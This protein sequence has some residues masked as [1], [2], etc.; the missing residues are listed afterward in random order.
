MNKE[1]FIKLFELNVIY[2]EYKE[3]IPFSFSLY[4]KLI[5]S[6]TFIFFGFDKDHN[7]RLSIECFEF[8]EEKKE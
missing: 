2:E 1:E 6:E 7:I 8:S 4:D 5:G 3:K